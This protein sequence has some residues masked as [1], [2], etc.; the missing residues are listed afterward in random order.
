MSR[1]A[2]DL[3]NPL[4]RLTNPL[5]DQFRPFHRDEVA[6]T[7]VCDCFCHEGLTGTGRTKEQNSFGRL[8]LKV[9]E[10]L[11]VPERPLDR[12][13]QIFLDLFKTTDLTP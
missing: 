13:L 10:D 9:T 3:S 8:G 11:R 7:L 6:F 12:F 2:E 1:F 4:L 5:G